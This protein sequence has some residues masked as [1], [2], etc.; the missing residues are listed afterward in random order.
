MVENE[1]GFT[2]ASVSKA[3]F[4]M[5]V[6]TLERLAYILSQ[7]R[8]VGVDPFLSPEKK[9]AIK[10][11]LVRQF[12]V[13][14]SPLLPEDIAKKYT[15]QLPQLRPKEANVIRKEGMNMKKVNQKKE[16][17]DWELEDKLDQLIVEVERHLQNEGYIMPPKDDPR[18]AVLKR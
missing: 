9:Q 12:I 5:A 4:N 18:F 7:I 14:A 1:L 15:D 2:P 6:N 11:H 10:V 3:P 8:A 13:Q 17:F 16:V